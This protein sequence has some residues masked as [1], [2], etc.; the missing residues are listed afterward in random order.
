M[1]VVD[2]RVHLVFISDMVNHV[3]QDIKGSFRAPEF[4]WHL[5][6]RVYIAIECKPHQQQVD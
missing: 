6:K 5:L 3:K 1:F 4:P 2:T